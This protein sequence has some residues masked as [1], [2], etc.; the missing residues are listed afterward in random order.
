MIKLEID[1]VHYDLDDA[2]RSRKH[3]KQLKHGDHRRE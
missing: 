3:S 1:S 2:L